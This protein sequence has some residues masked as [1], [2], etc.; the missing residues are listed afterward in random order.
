MASLRL[1]LRGPS[2]KQHTC[3]IA[4]D[5]TLADLL[6]EASAAFTIEGQVELLL[7]FPPAPCTS[8]AETC[9][10]DILRSGDTV[11]V[12]E[13][14][15]CAR[16][17]AHSSGKWLPPAEAAAA[18]EIAAKKA[19]AKAAAQEAERLAA[20]KRAAAE[21]AAA[22]KAAAENLAR[23]TWLCKGCSHRNALATQLCKKCGACGP[24]P[25]DL[26]KALRSGDDS[27][28][29]HQVAAL[30]GLA[31]N[32]LDDQGRTILHLAAAN[33][34]VRVMESV[35]ANSNFTAVNAVSVNGRTALHWATMKSLTSSREAFAAM[36]L[37]LNHPSFTLKDK[38]DNDGNTALHSAADAGDKD[39]C[40][41][42]INHKLDKTIRN[43]HGQTARDRANLKVDQHPKYPDCVIVL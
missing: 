41:L 28:C 26:L 32:G 34:L 6:A 16:E 23:E 15:D 25:A 5:K 29:L 8:S 40:M 27:D 39:V 11:T 31:I 10:A 7:G 43:N 13:A 17:Q 1:R 24:L 2:G 42:L 33:G 38:Q 36:E 18:T 9:L 3:N 20:E 21:K 14:S 19:S 22:E 12:R 35:L 30:E 4:S 37:L